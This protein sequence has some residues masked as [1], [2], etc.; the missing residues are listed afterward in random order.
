M[1]QILISR[2]FTAL[3]NVGNKVRIHISL[4]DGDVWWRFDDKDVRESERLRHKLWQP[5]EIWLQFVHTRRDNT[6]LCNMCYRNFHLFLR[7]KKS[8]NINDTGYKM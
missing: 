4:L 8:I 5:P 3:K 7:H 6:A 2:F 1:I